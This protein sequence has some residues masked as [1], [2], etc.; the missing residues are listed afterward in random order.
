VPNVLSI[1]G[2]DIYDPSKSLSPHR[3]PFVRGVVRRMLRR[4]DAVVAESSDI[5]H[6]ALEY[7]GVNRE[8]D[9]IP[10]GVRSQSFKPVARAALGLPED[11]LVLVTVGRLVRRKG[12][13]ELVELAAALDE[14]H[15]AT[16]VVIGAGPERGEIE[17][18]ASAQRPGLVVL[19]GRVSEQRKAELLMAADVYV[20]ASRHEGFGI[21]FLEAMKCGLPVVCYA[22][23]GQTDFLVDAES[24]FLADP[25]DRDGLLRGLRALA[26]DPQLRRRMGAF[27]A[28]AVKELSVDRCVDRYARLFRE[29][30]G[31]PGRGPGTGLDASGAGQR[32]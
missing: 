31:R 25:G 27:N 21:V 5:R 18:A 15:P 6:R 28:Q 23:G 16:L 26:S 17:A 3:T 1:L 9:L 11:T 30:L 12:V 32:I 29:V 7:Y 10:L 4:A 22:A 13:G 24:G 8:I 20:S 14:Q 19:P 2:G